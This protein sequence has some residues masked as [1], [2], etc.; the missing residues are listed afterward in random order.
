MRNMLKYSLCAARI[1]PRLHLIYRRMS[2]CPD[3]VEII[4]RARNGDRDCQ[5]RLAEQVRPR[6]HEYVFRMTL[7]HDE[8][9]DI[10]QETIVE[11]FRVF[12]KLRKAERFWNWL[13]GIAYNKLRDHRRRQSRRGRSLESVLE[14]PACTEDGDHAVAAM[15]SEELKDIVLRC[16]KQLEDRHRDVLVMRCYRRMQY[17]QIAEVMGI[18]EL[19]ARSLFCRAKRALS[20]RLT[21]YGLDKGS[22]LMALVLFGKITASSRT[23]AAE[24]SLSADTLKAGALANLSA[25]VTAKSA[26]L[27]AAGVVA[28]AAGSTAL[29][30]GPASAPEHVE[31]APVSVSIP[32]AQDNTNVERW[33]FYPAGSDG[34]VMTRHLSL[35]EKG[36]STCL[37]LQN[38]FGAYYH[39]GRTVTIANHHYYNPDLA[40]M[41][42][43]TDERRMS[44]FI[45]SVEGAAGFAERCTRTGDGLLVICR[46]MAARRHTI[47]R[48]DRHRNVL[49]EL[50]FQYDWPQSTVLQ[51]VRDDM[52]RRGWTHFTIKGRIHDRSIEARGRIPFTCA[53]YVKNYPW[54]Q[55]KVQGRLKYLDTGSEAVE[56][57]SVGSAMARYKPGAF[58]EGLS[59]PWMGL[60]TIDTIRR[61]AAERA[62]RF[63]TESTDNP[64]K[65]EIKLLCPDEVRLVHTVDLEK[66]VIEKVRFVNAR[67]TPQYLGELVFSYIADHDGVA[68]IFSPPPRNSRT[69]LRLNKSQPT[70]LQ[71]LITQ[72]P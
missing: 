49:E 34:P 55:V 38:Q 9:D 51:D 15:V 19:G 21:G 39:D 22:L 4:E 12:H 59:R 69:T 46:R 62:I 72:E 27:S 37:Y 25:A 24:V 11:M 28:V 36:E 66:D 57:D 29:N 14:S 67:K 44:D 7:H 50:F 13:C 1:V 58:F 6:L 71:K 5:N 54:L 3:Q 56:Y 2:E 32:A 40:V 41:R 68:R 18:S 10:T 47:W 23:A 61:D 16:M 33:H 53:A 60:H 52:H 17:S 64:G 70:W 20:R 63:E 48:I 26:V 42:L 65:V 30:T 45:T 8:A 35:D 43:P 31:P